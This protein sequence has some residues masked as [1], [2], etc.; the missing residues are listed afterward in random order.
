MKKCPFCA[1]EIQDAAIVCKH[2]GRAQAPAGA[3]AKGP[4]AAKKRHRLRNTFLVIAALIVLGSL[5]Q[6]INPPQ[7]S[8]S[9]SAV[10]GSGNRA[11]D[12]LSGMSEPDRAAALVKTLGGEPC[13]AVSRTFYQGILA[14]DR[15]A[16]WNV[17]CSNGRSYAISINNDATGSTRILDCK[18]LKTIA[19]VDCFTKFE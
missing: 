8:S 17:R 13:G 1:E 7:T 10:A 16:F 2:C 19:G 18:V 12:V 14:K 15:S 5:A 11:N 3:A 4:P 9:R 6:V